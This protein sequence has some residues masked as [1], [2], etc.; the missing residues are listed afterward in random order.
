MANILIV[1]DDVDIAQGIAEYLETVGHS[2]DFAYT[3]SQALSLI[4]TET[5]DLVLLDINLPFVNGFDVC[6][7]LTDTNLASQLAS[8][9]VIF[10]SAR[11]SEKDI[12]KGFDLGAWDYLVKPFSF[13]ELSARI[14]VNLMKSTTEFRTTIKFAYKN[15]SLEANTL[16]FC[17]HK[18]SIQ[19]H[20]VG[21]DIMKMLIASAPDVV[22]TSAIHQRLWGDN[23]PESDPLRAHVYK[24]RQQLLENYGQAFIVTIKGVGYKFDIDSQADSL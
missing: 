14:N 21:F 13:A 6:R 7:A 11:S 1:E 5:F 3:G 18:K 12:L 20:R 15:V 16:T 19:L 10:M 17:Y 23:T 2:L 8:V 22:K 24:L 9:P 4:D